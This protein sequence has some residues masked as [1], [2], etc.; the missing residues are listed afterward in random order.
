MTFQIEL[1][2]YITV[3]S[4]KDLMS[5][6]N[7]KEYQTELLDSCISRW[8]AAVAISGFINKG[9]KNFINRRV[10]PRKF[11]LRNIASV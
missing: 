6:E 7:E 5:S 11:L 9:A 3:F 1:Q 8:P 10:W 4:K 2:I